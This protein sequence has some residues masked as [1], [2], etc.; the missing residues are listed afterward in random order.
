MY[1]IISSIVIDDSM[2]IKHEYSRKQNAK[3]IVK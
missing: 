3:T 1:F 2:P